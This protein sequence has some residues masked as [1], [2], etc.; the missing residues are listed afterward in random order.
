M[1]TD[2]TPNPDKDTSEAGG[3]AGVQPPGPPITSQPAQKP[4]G[5]ASGGDGSKGAGG[6]D[7]FGRGS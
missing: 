6:P 7:G 2:N 5:P 1:V 4:V 3:K